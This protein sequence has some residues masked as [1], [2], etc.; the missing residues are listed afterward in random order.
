MVRIYIDNFLIEAKYQKLFNQT[1]QKL[2]KKYKFKDLK[3][4]KIIIKQQMI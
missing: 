2:K 1:K 3:E 4:V